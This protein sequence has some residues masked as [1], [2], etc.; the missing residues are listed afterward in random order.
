MIVRFVDTMRDGSEDY[1]FML[2]IDFNNS[3]IGRD[4]VEEMLLPAKWQDETNCDYS[5][6]EWVEE[7]LDRE[8]ISHRE[9]EYD[10]EIEW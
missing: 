2:D 5:Y 6:Q 9:V 10:V 8:R 7:T 1:T 3:S 4:M